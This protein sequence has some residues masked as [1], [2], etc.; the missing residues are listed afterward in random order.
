MTNFIKLQH[1]QNHPLS[2]FIVTILIEIFKVIK[3]DHDKMKILVENTAIE[4][5]DHAMKSDDI[6][7]SKRII[8]EFLGAIFNSVTYRSSNELKDV[9][10]SALKTLT[11]KN[12]SYYATFFF[13]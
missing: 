10:S 8:L 4:L 11:K 7:P 5:M 6:A 3:D 9:F 1:R 12:L 13:Q 2:C